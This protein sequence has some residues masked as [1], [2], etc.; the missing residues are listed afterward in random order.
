M[1]IPARGGQGFKWNPS[2]NPA[3]SA[4]LSWT[5]ILSP[6]L[7][8]EARAG[9]SRLN[10]EV[11]SFT[12]EWL[13]P[14][15]GLN[16]PRADDRITGL[17][18]INFTGR[19]G[20]TSIGESLFAPTQKISQNWQ[21]LDNVTAIRSSHTMKA[22]IDLRFTRADNFSPQSGHGQ[23][24]FNGRFTGVSMADFLLGM[25]NSYNQTNLQYV[26]GR[27][28]SYMFYFQDDWKVTPRLTLNLGVRYELTTPMWNKYDRQ[29]RIILEPGPQFG[30]FQYAGAGDGSLEDRALI[31]LDTNN[32]APRIGL[33][34]RAG[35]RWTTRAGF[36]VF[37]GGLDRIGTGARMMANWPF[38]VRKGL[39][40]TPAI[41]AVL[42][43]EGV[44]AD[45]VSAG[46]TLPANSDL[47]SWSEKFPITQIAQWNASVQRQ[48]SG[49][50]V[51]EVAYVGSSTSYIRD[52][53]NMNAPMPGD[54]ATEIQRRLI[55]SIN[56]IQLHTPFGHSSY[57]GLDVQLEKR[58]SQ[59]FLFSLGYGWGH[60]IANVGE[61]WGPD[62]GMQNVWNFDANRGTTGFNIRHRFVASYVYELPFGRGPRR[63]NRNRTADL[64][65]GGWNLNG[66]TS[67]SSGRPY[68][69][70]LPNARVELGTA[71]VQQWRPDRIAP[72]SVD[73]PNPERWF[74]PSAF[75]RPCDASGCR[76]GNAGVNILTSGGQI[77]TDFGLTK[78][79]PLTERFRLQLRVEAFNLFNTPAFDVPNSNLENP[80]AGKVRS[81][82]S[83]PRVFQYALR[84]GI[85]IWAHFAH[86]GEYFVYNCRVN[87][88]GPLWKLSSSIF[89]I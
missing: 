37:Y 70:T 6:S 24:D 30:T 73:D 80:D 59:G 23:F 57:N 21:F 33:A 5:K 34:Y 38:N 67:M 27:F 51:L 39:V 17:P 71:A 53:Y 64:I 62:V 45:F 41:P 55:P 22:G 87:I 60:A 54:P 82:V 13:A 56:S 79:F 2:H 43:R 74:D 81:T 44:P 76:L 61:Q 29:N 68:T 25:A 3:H 26:D 35:E 20:Y 28:R 18:R 75:V 85:L 4:A 58:Y 50:L 48:I 46:E 7:I 8:N 88:P 40:S 78:Y 31:R 11:G 89:V 1:P 84:L 49:N 10:V 66:I 47:F 16:I 65:F 42:L 63:A 86:N 14:E 77:N 36:G 72:G 83:T 12:D 32:W 52:S 9:F 19:L 69:P 15:Y